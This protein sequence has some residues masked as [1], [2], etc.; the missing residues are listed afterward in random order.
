[1]N[2]YINPAWFYWIKVLD[3]TR[4]ISIVS[5]VIFGAAIVF[6][7][8]AYA[9]ESDYIFDEEDER[10]LARL[11][12]LIK[13]AI[14]VFVIAVLCAIFIPDKNTLIEMQIARYATRENV[15]AT[16]ES[17]KSFVD[18]IVESISKLK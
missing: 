9:S 4:I 15:D 10:T 8:I 5:A 7:S 11:H 18:Y 12:R 1:M 6:L 3:E 14:A 16:I 13:L 2:Y 17:I